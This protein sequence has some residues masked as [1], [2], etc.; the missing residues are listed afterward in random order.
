MCRRSLLGCWFLSDTVKNCLELCKYGKQPVKW[1]AGLLYALG[2]QVENHPLCRKTPMPECASLLPR[3]IHLPPGEM[4]VSSPWE[5]ASDQHRPGGEKAGLTLPY[6]DCQLIPGLGNMLHFCLSLYPASPIHHFS[7]VLC[8]WLSRCP[9]ANNPNYGFLNPFYNLHSLHI[10]QTSVQITLLLR[11]LPILS[12][13]G[14]AILCVS[15][16]YLS[17]GL[18]EGRWACVFCL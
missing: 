2:C 18:S 5:I 3:S 15:S 7:M 11:L 10:F 14:D 4:P 8:G 12:A 9:F 13:V 6:L 17:S 1:I 16:L